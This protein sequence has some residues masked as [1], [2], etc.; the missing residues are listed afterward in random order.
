M[1]G[2]KVGGGVV[3]AAVVVVVVVAVV[4]VAAVVVL[5]L[6]LLVFRAWYLRLETNVWYSFCAK[7]ERICV[8]KQQCMVHILT[9]HKT[10]KICNSSILIYRPD[11][12]CSITV[13]AVTTPLLTTALSCAV[14]RSCMV[15][16][17]K[18]VK[19]EAASRAAYDI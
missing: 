4:V 19:R 6:V 11:L 10:T 8:I 7:E 18:I 14:F 3:V 1:P 13:A 16:K 9:L 2:A 15:K 12:T 5:V 17:S